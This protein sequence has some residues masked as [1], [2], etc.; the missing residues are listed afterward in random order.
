MGENRKELL[1]RRIRQEIKFKNMSIFS[2]ISLKFIPKFEYLEVKAN[3]S[4]VM[5]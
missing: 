3:K 4:Q 1:K 5:I 2:R